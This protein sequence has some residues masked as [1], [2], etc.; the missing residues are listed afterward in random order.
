MSV[1]GYGLQECV[2]Q[3]QVYIVLRLVRGCDKNTHT[4]MYPSKHRREREREG[5]EG[6]CVGTDWVRG[7]VVQIK[8][9][10]PYNLYCGKRAAGTVINYHHHTHT[11]THKRPHAHTHTHTNASR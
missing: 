11:H 1:F 8:T 7:G 4:H 5:E 10:S 6:A 9:F 2:Y 3:F